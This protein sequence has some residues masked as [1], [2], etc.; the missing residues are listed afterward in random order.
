MIEYSRIHGSQGDVWQTY[1]VD[2][3]LQDE[4]PFSLGCECSADDIDP[5][6]RIMAQN[7][8]HNLKDLF[9][10]NWLNMCKSTFIRLDCSYP[11][12][13]G[14]TPPDP[15][16]W[17]AKSKLLEVTGQGPEAILDAL[18]KYYF[19]FGCGQLGRFNAFR[20]DNGLQPIAHPIDNT[21]CDYR[22]D[23]Q[24][25]SCWTYPVLFGRRRPIKYSAFRRQRHR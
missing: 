10:L 22:Y 21:G 5:Q 8:L 24:K 16:R 3:L 1:F 19:Q 15:A 12:F 11:Y 25:R 9:N 17:E 2:L 20:W 6:L 4:N 14:M 7:D 23:Y 13:K 18:E